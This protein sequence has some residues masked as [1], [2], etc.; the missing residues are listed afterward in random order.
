[1]AVNM[2]VFGL[3]AL[4]RQKFQ[5]SDITMEVGGSRSHSDFFLKSSQN[6]PNPV[7]VFWSSTIPIDY[8]RPTMCILAAY[9]L[10]KVVGYYDL[11]VCP[12][13]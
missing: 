13:Q 2:E 7:L 9:P 11:S 10:L 5:K 1:M 4:Q 8:N 12:C 6:I 3:G